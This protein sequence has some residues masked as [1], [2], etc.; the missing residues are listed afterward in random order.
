M[1]TIIVGLGRIGSEN[2]CTDFGYSRSHVGALYLNGG[3]ELVGAVETNFDRAS[4]ARQQWRWPSDFPISESLTTFKGTEPELVVLATGPNG[5]ADLVRQAIELSPR[6]ILIEKPVTTSL[7]EAVEIN[8][9]LEKAGIASQVMFHRHYDPRHLALKAELGESRPLFV[10]A[11][12]NKG[13]FNYGSHMLDLLQSL[14]GSIATVR[15]IPMDRDVS[16]AIDPS[17]SFHCCF[18]AGGSATVQGMDRVPYDQFEMDLFFSD[19][20]VQLNNGGCEILTRQVTA[21]LYYPGYAHMAHPETLQTVAD[22]TSG[23]VRGFD[24]LYTAIAKFLEYGKSLSGCDMGGAVIIQ[25]ILE[26]VKESAR[27]KGQEISVED[28][29]PPGNHHFSM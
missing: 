5:R 9:Q 24:G 27:R 4:A 14:C 29:L 11:R 25:A 23:P 10:Q 13:L 28:V 21:D 18:A 8:Q 2:D 15:H 1:K 3:F 26:A 6:L 7:V 17:L 16:E 19:K 22:L 12:Y 20:V